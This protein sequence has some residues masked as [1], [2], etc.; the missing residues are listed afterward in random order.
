[1]TAC[2]VERTELSGLGDAAL[3]QQ[4]ALKRNEALEE[5]YTLYAN[6]GYSLAMRITGEPALAGSAVVRAFRRIRDCPEAFDPEI[7][8]PVSWVLNLVRTAAVDLLRR[9]R[10]GNVSDQGSIPNLLADAVPERQ[11]DLD[12]NNAQDSVL[13]AR[14]AVVREAV[15]SLAAD[16]RRTLD[17]AFFQGYS[18]DEIARLSGEPVSIVVD[19][20]REAMDTLVEHIAPLQWV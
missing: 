4:I 12:A 14:R 10:T 18:C 11:N 15:Q 3:L 16:R 7:N 13:T 9:H 6:L 2:S 17:L 19:Q 5:L 20:L 8:V 1:M